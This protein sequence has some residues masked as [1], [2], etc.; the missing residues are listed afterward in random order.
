[1]DEENDKKLEDEYEEYDVEIE[2]ILNDKIREK[3]QNKTKK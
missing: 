1:M 2:Q 3:D